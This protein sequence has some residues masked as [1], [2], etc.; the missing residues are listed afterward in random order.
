MTHQTPSVKP[1]SPAASEAGAPGGGSSTS[2]ALPRPAAP[3]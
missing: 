2:S 3:H 1:R